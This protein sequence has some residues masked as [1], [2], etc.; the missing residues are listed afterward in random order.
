MEIT[1]EELNELLQKEFERGKQANV[2]TTGFHQ[3]ENLKPLPKSPYYT[4]DAIPDACKNCTNHPSNGGSGICNCI[5]GNI[6]T[7]AVK[8]G[9]TVSTSTTTTASINND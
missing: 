3:I 7:Y 4:W 9:K 1:I 6:A 8:T 2:M 5:L